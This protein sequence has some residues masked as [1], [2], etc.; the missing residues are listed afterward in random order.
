MEIIQMIWNSLTTPNEELFKILTFPLIFLE[1]YV[2]MLLFTTILDITADKS[3]KF[4]YSIVVSLLLF[5]AKLIIPHPISS[6]TNMVLIPIMIIAIFQTSIVK[7][8]IAEFL[9]FII[10]SLLETTI[11]K[12]ALIVFNVPYESLTTIP[13][14]RLICIL[15]IYIIIFL[16]TKLAKHFNFNIKILENMDKSTKM[17]I[18]FNVILGIIAIGVQFYLITFY[19]NTLPVLITLFGILSL[20]AYFFIS[21]YNLTNTT[22]LEIA[23]R[24]IENLQLY[25]KTLTILHDNIRA[26]RHDFSNI[27]QVI[28]RIC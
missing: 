20:L 14:Y 2:S 23:N 9:P 24:D 4:M 12:T 21:I 17:I 1:G 5:L 25:N 6:F 15:L 3:Q 7:S 28:G 22:K 16:F 18:G 27:V 19:S 26:F 13:I 11:F 8:I 10:T